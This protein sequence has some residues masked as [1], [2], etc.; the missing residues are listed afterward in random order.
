MTL[1][2]LPRCLTDEKVLETKSVNY[3]KTRL[4]EKVLNYSSDFVVGNFC[5]VSTIYISTFVCEGKKLKKKKDEK[6][7]N[8]NKE[9]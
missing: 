5:P 1:P 4:S 8:N 3:Y 7:K 6:T 9:K 2:S